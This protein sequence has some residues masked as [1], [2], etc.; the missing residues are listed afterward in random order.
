MK[1]SDVPCPEWLQKRLEQ[2][3][4]RVA[5]STYMDWALHDP[6]HGA[7]GAGQLQVGT[8]GDFVTSPSL[9]EDFSGLLMHQLIEWLEILAARHPD[10]LLSLVDVGPG[11][12]DLIAQLIQLFET[13]AAHLFDR[14]E[15]VLVDINP[16]MQDRQRQRLKASA[17]C[18]CR[19]CSLAE[20]SS[21]PVIGVM[22]AHELLDALPVERL[23]LK[24]G[25]LQRQMVALQA[26]GEA[27]A[28]LVWADDPLPEAL[29]LQLQIQME[30]DGLQLP[31]V[32][33]E[34]G[35]ATEWHHCVKNWMQQGHA[36]MADGMLLVVDYALESSRYYTARRSDGTLVAYRRQQASSD[37]LRDPGCQDITAHLCV[38]S[39]VGDAAAAGWI[40][41]GH[42]RQGEALLAL[43]LAER[44][45]ALQQFAGDQLAEA[46]RRREA[47]LR[48]VDPSCLGELRWFSFHRNAPAASGEDLP[49]SRYLQEPC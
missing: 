19:W 6:V 3:G 13:S 21:N 34:D 42:C 16:G 36:S 1:A 9:G 8:D 15:F 39:L 29:Q 32:G 41:D 10:S 49:P 38:E 7:Y 12:G 24:D 43:G 44:L 22:L 2:H 18:R 35:W 47:L 33:A 23:V 20:L 4:N 45:N 31:P 17:G 46:L 48:L 37:V 26:P 28:S 5:F 11:E 14:L 30:R 27:L 40:L 25:S